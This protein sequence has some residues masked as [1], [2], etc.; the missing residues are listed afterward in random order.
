MPDAKDFAPNN[1]VY[2]K[3]SLQPP[4][5]ELSLR[6]EFEDDR[7]DM[8]DYLLIGYFHEEGRGIRIIE[9]KLLFKKYVSRGGYYLDWQP[10]IDSKSFSWIICPEI[11][12]HL[13]ITGV[14]HFD[15][16]L[17]LEALNK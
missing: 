15:Q 6:G 11:Q 4:L 12:D 8:I 14:V 1:P 9:H 3:E 13:G 5:R 17:E 7:G 16:K 10:E 2:Q